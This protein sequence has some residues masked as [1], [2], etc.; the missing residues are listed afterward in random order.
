MSHTGDTNE[1]VG[2]GELRAGSATI[3]VTSSAHQ[4]ITAAEDF[5]I[6]LEHLVEGTE[7]RLGRACHFMGAWALELALKS[8]V[9]QRGLS[10]DDLKKD[11][12][13]LQKLWRKA[14]ELDLP[15]PSEP[16]H[17]C[18]LLDSLHDRPFLLRYPSSYNGY[19]SPGRKEMTAEL[20]KLV[21][22]VKAATP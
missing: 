10:D 15:I 11:G 18:V 13:G 22:L 9:S 17:W 8:H 5:V 14:A 16:P 19:V 21:T 6:A 12:H 20:Q 2:A 4:F 3:G 1:I 7:S